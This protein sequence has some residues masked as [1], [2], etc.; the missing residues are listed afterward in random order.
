MTTDN[1][2]HIDWQQINRLPAFDIYKLVLLSLGRDYYTNGAHPFGCPVIRGDGIRRPEPDTDYTDRLIVAIENARH[3]R[4][5]TTGKTS[6]FT[7][8]RTTTKIQF[9][10]PG[11]FKVHSDEPEVI[12]SKFDLYA[13]PFDA[14]FWIVDTAEFRRFCDLMEWSAP[15]E[16]LPLGYK[17]PTAPVATPAALPPT[18]ATP[19]A[20]PEVALPAAGA[21]E[22]SLPTKDIATCFDGLNGWDAETWPKRLSGAKWLHPARTALGGKGG[23]PS[24]WNP[25]TLAQLVHDKTKGQRPREQILKTFNNR[26]NTNPVLE[27]WKT[28]FNEYFAMFSDSD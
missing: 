12:P 20:V 27:P 13:P 3:G 2:E 19:T 11:G 25:L 18:P 21:P 8:T 17:K 1:T 26:F 6:P 5:P 16:F 22:E 10:G 7:T 23:A 14:Q 28:A 4:L 24:M 15:P 9:A